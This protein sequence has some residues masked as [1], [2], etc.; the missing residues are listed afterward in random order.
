MHKR[1]FWRKQTRAEETQKTMGS[2][3]ESE[4]EL[5]L[6]LEMIRQAMLTQAQ[7]GWGTMNSDE[8]R[9]FEQQKSNVL[10]IIAEARG[11][12]SSLARDRV[13]Y[14]ELQKIQAFCFTHLHPVEEATELSESMALLTT[15]ARTYGPRA[16]LAEDQDQDG[17]RKSPDDPLAIPELDVVLKYIRESALE[18][19]HTRRQEIRRDG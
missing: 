3:L 8:N 15:W 13:L 10:G 18:L 19:L 9:S 12:V 17:R 16:G 11:V 6:E 14:R 1:F 4:L 7:E 2:E 5:E